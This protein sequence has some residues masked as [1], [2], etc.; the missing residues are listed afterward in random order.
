MFYIIIHVWLV[1]HVQFVYP[2]N[3][4][5]RLGLVQNLSLPDRG[6][7]PLLYRDQEHDVR[8]EV[9]T[10]CDREHWETGKSPI[11]VLKYISN[12]KSSFNFSFGN[13]GALTVSR[14]RL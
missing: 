9:E 11:T 2:S 10:S 13:F 4:R 6:K 5:F 7:V 1:L 8:L 3:R 12:S 14:I